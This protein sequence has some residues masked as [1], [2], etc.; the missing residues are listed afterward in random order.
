MVCPW[1]NETAN[2][3]PDPLA[4]QART[5]DFARVR[6]ASEYTELASPTPG[7]WALALWQAHDPANRV[8]LHATAVAVP[9]SGLYFVDPIPLRPAAV[10]ELLAQTADTPPAGVLVTNGNHARAA[11]EFARRFGVPLC[12]MATVA[13][14]AGLEVSAVVPDTGG[15]VFGGAFEAVPLPGAAAGEVAF[16]RADGGGLV[17]IGDALIHMGSHGFAVLPEKYCENFRELR[18]SLAR[19]AERTFSTMT[20]A[21]GEPLVGRADGRLRNLLAG[22]SI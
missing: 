17:V 2:I 9:E 11:G 10:A 1:A 4:F 12:A 16:Y 19:L 18:R 15:V 8:D 22:Q 6:A 7:A 3:V 21:H 13:A 20:F 5:P 14:E